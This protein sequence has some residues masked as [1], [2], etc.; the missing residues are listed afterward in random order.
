MV[1][2]SVNQS[3][4]FVIIEETHAATWLF[5]GGN[6]LK[7]IILNPLPL[8]TCNSEGMGKRLS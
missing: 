2:A 5:K 1:F 4:S 6:I 7:R 8:L 3:N